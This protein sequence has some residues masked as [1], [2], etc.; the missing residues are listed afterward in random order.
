MM[1]Q[2]EKMICVLLACFGITV[3]GAADSREQWVFHLRSFSGEWA[4]S[5]V[6]VAGFLT[7]LR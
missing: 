3:D 2:K 1:Q 5:K 7:V 4:T 6:F